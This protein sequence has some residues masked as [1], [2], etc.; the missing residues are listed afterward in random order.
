MRNIL[1]DLVQR[2]TANFSL[3]F[4]G[5]LIGSMQGNIP[6]ARDPKRSASFKVLKQPETPAVLI[7]LGYMSN[8]EDLARLT[9]PDGQRH[10]AAT[11]AAAIETYFAKRDIKLGR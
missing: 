8:T 4:R 2:E 10:L 11:I 7:E 3:S 5:L 9:K 1:L 6:L